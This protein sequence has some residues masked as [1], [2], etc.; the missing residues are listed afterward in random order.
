MPRQV[1]QPPPALTKTMFFPVNVASLGEQEMSPEEVLDLHYRRDLETLPCTTDRVRGELVEEAYQRLLDGH[2]P[3][4]GLNLDIVTRS[5]HE[6]M[7][8]LVVMGLVSEEDTPTRE[9]VFSTLMPDQ[10]NLSSHQRQILEVGALASK[11]A[12][13]YDVRGEAG[14]EQEG[15]EVELNLEQWCQHR[16]GHVRRDSLMDQPGVV[17]ALALQ[18]S[19]KRIHSARDQGEARLVNR[20]GTSAYYS[21]VRANLVTLGCWLGPATFFISRSFNPFSEVMLAAW[22]SHTAGVEGKVE[23]VWH[24][25]SEQQLLTLRPGREL[26]NTGHLGVYYVHCR[27]QVE[28]DSCPFHTW[29]SRKPLEEWRERYVSIIYLKDT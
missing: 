22:C 15:R 13:L 1:G 5:I 9:R 25:G 16:L 20:P 21:Q 6:S 8:H 19:A 23:K 2:P 7:E 27:S 11:I 12:P 28:E 24:L 18:H 26:E 4:G 3:Y 10:A 29:C 14:V 17:L